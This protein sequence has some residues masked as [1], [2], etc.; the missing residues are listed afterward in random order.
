MSEAAY[1]ILSSALSFAPRK[2]LADKP[3]S[4]RPR[5]IDPEAVIEAIELDPSLTTDDLAYE[6]ECG[7]TS[8]KKI[9]KE[10]GKKWKRVRWVPHKLKA[11]HT[12]TA[13]KSV[14]M[15]HRSHFTPFLTSLVTVDEKWIFLVSASWHPVTWSTRHS[16]A[17]SKPACSEGYAHNILGSRRSDSLG[18][19]TQWSTTIN[20]ECYCEHLDRCN[21]A[22][23]RPRRR[24][25]V[26]LQD[27]ARPYV[28]RLTQVKLK[29]LGWEWLNYPPYSPDLSPSGY[30][31]FRPLEHFLSLASLTTS[32][33]F[34]K[35]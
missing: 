11:I 14:K 17:S 33:I 24:N 20:T 13:K 15:L 5:E 12:V 7:T 3:R 32:I 21:Q 18:V 19:V 6:F 28:A 25:I 10:A 26:L 1:Y 34:E 4:G 23:P 30:H 16:N 29:E 27:N 22:T 35:D 9:L 2:D 8:I 31:L